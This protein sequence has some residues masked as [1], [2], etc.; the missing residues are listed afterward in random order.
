MAARTRAAFAGSAPLALW[1]CEADY[2]AARPGG[3]SPGTGG[4]AARRLA[5]GRTA[6]GKAGAAARL[7]AYC[8][9]PMT[10]AA[11]GASVRGTAVV[12]STI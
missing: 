6:D 9:A 4:F 7:H 5:S 11:R 8:G 1:W 10:R 2:R 12:V 3:A